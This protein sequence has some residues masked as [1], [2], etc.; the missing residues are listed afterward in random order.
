[1]R[2]ERRRQVDADQAARPASTRTAATRARCSST[3][4]PRSFATPRDAERAGI[5]VIHQELAL[6]AEMTVAENMLLGRAAA[7]ARLIDWDEVHA[8]AR[9]APGRFGSSSTPDPRRR[10]RR[11]PAAARRDRARRRQEVRRSWCSTSRPRRSRARDR[12]LLALVASCA[13]RR[14]VH[15]H[16]AQAG[17]GVRHRRP[18]HRAARRREH[19]HPAARADECRRRSSGTWSGA[20][21]TICSRAVAARPASRCSRSRRSA[22][23]ER[24]GVPAIAARHSL[25]VRAGEVLGIGGLMGAGRTELLMHLFGAVGSPRDGHGRAQ[26]RADAD[27]DDP[28]DALRAAWRWSREDRKRYGLVLEHGVDVQSLALQSAAPGPPPAAAARPHEIARRAHVRD[29]PAHQDAPAR[30]VGRCPA[31]T[32]RRS[33]SARRCMTEPSVLLLD[34]PTRGIDV[35][36]KLEIYELI[37]RLTDAGQGRRAGVE[38]AAGADGHERPHRDAARG[39]RR[40][41]VRARRSDPGALLAAAMGRIGE[42]A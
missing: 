20:R 10:A 33:C 15:L 7:A 16:L 14:G 28:A 31:A 29:A 12:A 42:A 27:T 13:P 9:A 5:A 19:R 24:P 35:G 6:V 8:R 26:R 17:R 39:P 37:N 38:R 4:S 25:T 22:W 11:R 23:R 3:A 2:R 30:A 21:S 41:R 34:E 36:A 1:M 40:R 32:S 18:H